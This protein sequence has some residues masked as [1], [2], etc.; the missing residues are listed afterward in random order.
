MAVRQL[1]CYVSWVQTVQEL[2]VDFLTFE[3][4]EPRGYKRHITAAIGSDSDVRNQLISVESALMWTIPRE[5]FGVKIML[6]KPQFSAR[7]D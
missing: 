4:F 3:P 6:D 2:I 7:R 5:I 1:K